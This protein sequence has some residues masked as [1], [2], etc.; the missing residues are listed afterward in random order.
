MNILFLS[1][2][3]PYPLD[4]GPKVRSY[5]VLRY[6]AQFHRVTLVTFTRESD[7]ADALAH[8]ET[9]CH[10]VYPVP[11][12]RNRARDALYLIKS[13][14]QGRPFLIVRDD[15]H[16]MN[17]RLGTLTLAES[18][19]VVH[20][21]QLSMA[22]YA[23]RLQVP[24]RVLDQ[25]NA[26]WTIMQRLA[27][28]ETSRLKRAGIMRETRL[29]KT[30]EAVTCAQF[31]HVVTVTE[32]DRIALTFPDRAPR[33]PL[34]TIPICIDPRAIKPLLFNAGARDL[35]C[36]GGMFYPPNVDGMVWFVRQVLPLIW[37]E[38]PETRMYIVGGRPAPEL[39]ALGENESRII[40][41]GYVSDTNEYLARSA[42]FIVPLRAGGG[43]RVKILDAWARGVPMVST[44]VGAEGIVFIPNVNI[45]IADTP[46]EFAQATLRLIQDRI[47]AMRVAQQGR[48]WVETHY[49]WQRVYPA[50]DTIYASPKTDNRDKDASSFVR[51]H[52]EC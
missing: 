36:V 11:L 29:L 22:L 15:L 49:A 51:S 32:Q 38:A 26:V 20:A 27:E 52:L 23:L 45:L 44:T 37:K 8:L 24:C 17:E 6:L 47:F 41:T 34:Q 10:A 35:V 9:F 30:Y 12:K 48:Q 42:V 2:V 3:L 43:M 28:N 50:W 40:V 39:L 5:Y 46:T 1:Q 18:F 19:D 31:D 25:H 14:V 33:A 13:F 7:S 16:T 21:D 4:A